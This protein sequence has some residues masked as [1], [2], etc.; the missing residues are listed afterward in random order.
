[1]VY[2]IRPPW[3]KE[4]ATLQ[5]A[6]ARCAVADLSELLREGRLVELDTV[7]GP[8]MFP[9]ATAPDAAERITGKSLL[10]IF[11]EYVAGDP[12]F[13]ASVNREAALSRS[14]KFEVER[15]ALRAAGGQDRWPFS[16][17]GM[18]WNV[19]TS[20]SDILIPGTVGCPIGFLS[21]EARD[22]SAC[23]AGVVAE[24]RIG[25]VLDL[26]RSDAVTIQGLGSDGSVGNIL[27]A[28][29]DAPDH[30]IDLEKGKLFQLSYDEKSTVLYSALSI[31][32]VAAIAARDASVSSARAMTKSEAQNIAAFIEEQVRLLLPSDPLTRL[33]QHGAKAEFV[34]E[35]EPHC[36]E[37]G[38][39]ALEKALRAYL[40]V[41]R[42]KKQSPPQKAKSSLKI[43]KPG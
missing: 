37:W 16:W 35:I 20:A 22:D 10:R 17:P 32:A 42:N 41:L 38:T 9:A 31:G 2:F 11:Q 39:S 27:S 7:L 21:D 43:V 25:A 14:S 29:W 1:M 23:D 6:C 36:S 3:P 30:W 13:V 24:H 34:R 40:T 28:F 26:F 15:K 33:D 5:E 18:F 4:G 8:R 12:E 19:V